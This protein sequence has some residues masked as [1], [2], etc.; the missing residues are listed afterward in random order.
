MDMFS[1]G[2]QRIESAMVAREKMQGSITSNIA[3]ADTPNYQADK[4][5]FTDFLAEQ[6]RQ[7]ST[8]RADTTHRMHIENTSSTRLSSGIFHQDSAR[9]MD[10]NSVD[11]QT[12]MAR[13]SENQ[14]MHE[15]SMRLLKGKLGGLLNAIKEGRR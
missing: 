13:M 11:V 1:G 8:S 3:N 2:F 12:E 9:K 4:R 6:N 14:L 10:G 15:L 5:N 7:N